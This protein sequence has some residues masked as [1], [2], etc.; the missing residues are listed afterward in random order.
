MVLGAWVFFRGW[1]T[2]EDYD[3][4]KEFKFKKNKEYIK[5]WLW[6]SWSG[7]WLDAVECLV[8]WP[9]EGCGM[10]GQ[11][12]GQKNHTGVERMLVYLAMHVPGLT[13]LVMRPEWQH[14]IARQ[15]GGRV[16]QSSVDELD[17]LPRARRGYVLF[18]S[19]ATRGSWHRLSV[20]KSWGGGGCRL[21]LA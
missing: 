3:P 13:I 9:V 4:T 18:Y 19:Q 1:A 15:V 8:R 20:G 14:G 16:F 10:V 2:F 11:V 12:A 21:F 17:E 5:N 6:N 7:D